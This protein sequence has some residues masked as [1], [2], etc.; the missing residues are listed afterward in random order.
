[1]IALRVCTQLLQEYHVIMFAKSDLKGSVMFS[2]VLHELCQFSLDISYP[3]SRSPFL[4]GGVVNEMKAELP[5]GPENLYESILS[6]LSS[7][8][9]HA[10]F[11]T[12]SQAETAPV[13]CQDSEDTG[14]DNESETM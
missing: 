14:S 11:Q 6:Y 4:S 9:K 10:Y 3:I 2:I 7:R 1:M 12:S 5:L 8:S 13:M